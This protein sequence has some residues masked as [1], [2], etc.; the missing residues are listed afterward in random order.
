MTWRTGT[1]R[2]GTWRAGTW[3]GGAATP[4]PAVPPAPTFGVGGGRIYGGGRTVRQR[5]LRDDEMIW[6]GGGRR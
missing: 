5:Y 3:A 6:M 4:P 2:T 1:W